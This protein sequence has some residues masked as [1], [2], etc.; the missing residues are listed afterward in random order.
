[1]VD[2]A[3]N[4]GGS[5]PEYYDR[6][7]G[8]AHFERY[9]DDLVRRV[10][11]RPARDVLEVACGTGIVTRRLRQ[12]I[13]PSLRLV[14]TDLSAPMLE[15]AASKVQGAIEWRTADAQAL[16]FDPAVFGALVCAFGIMFV[17]D[18]ALA[19]REARRVLVKGGLLVFNVW[20]GLENNPHGA[21]ACERTRVRHRNAARHAARCPH[22]QAR[23]PARNRHRRPG[24]EARAVRGRSAV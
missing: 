19:M 22:G 23:T 13:D 3:R 20:D 1:M 5:I 7:L 4:F 17:P 21:A 16:P 2:T 18:K 24:R 11:A 8:R 12:R 14:A 6:I 9:A 10:P 15:Y